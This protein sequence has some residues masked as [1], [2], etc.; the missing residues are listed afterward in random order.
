MTHRELRDWQRYEATVSP[1]PDRLAD[2]HFAL[3][4]SLVINRTRSSDSEPVAMSDFYLIK[5][6]PPTFEDDGLTE[7]ERA[8]KIWRGG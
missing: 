6:A 1:L 5:E 8:A 2:M 3:L 4:S 7:S